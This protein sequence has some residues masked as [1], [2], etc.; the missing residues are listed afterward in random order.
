MD[1]KPV[2]SIRVRTKLLGIVQESEV[3]YIEKPAWKGPKSE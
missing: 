1:Y 2:L 3:V